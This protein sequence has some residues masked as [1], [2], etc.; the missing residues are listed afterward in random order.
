MARKR[1]GT[2]RVW[3]NS[4]IFGSPRNFRPT[5]HKMVQFFL[6]L[7]TTC[8]LIFQFNAPVQPIIAGASGLRATTFDPTFSGFVIGSFLRMYHMMIKYWFAFLTGGLKVT[9]SFVKI[10]CRF[11][12]FGLFSR[13]FRLFEMDYTTCWEK[14]GF[15]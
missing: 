3:G 4:S 7:S 8:T 10:D 6:V 9:S 1:F 2:N 5:K 15:G 12:Q 14:T 11:Q 13:K